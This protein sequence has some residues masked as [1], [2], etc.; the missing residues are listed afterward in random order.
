MLSK[1][2]PKSEKSRLV[3][4]VFSGTQFGSLVMLPVAGFLASSVGGWPSIFYVGGVIALVWVLAWCLMGANSPAE[5]HTISEAEKKYII[6]SLSNTTSKKVIYIHFSIIFFNFNK[7]EKIIFIVFA[8]SMEQDNK[9]HAHVDAFN[10]TYGTKL[11][12]LDFIN[13]HANLYQL[14]TEI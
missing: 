9:I 13:E 6:T 12:I 14:H 4:F 2:A 11:G 10:L 1:W 3:S 5:H 8:N 7:L